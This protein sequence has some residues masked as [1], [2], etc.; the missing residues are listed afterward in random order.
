MRTT[1]FGSKIIESAEEV[2]GY[3]YRSF[4]RNY[5]G[6][7]LEVVVKE[8]DSVSGTSFFAGKGRKQPDYCA[9]TSSIILDKAFRSFDGSVNAIRSA[10][11]NTLGSLARSTGVR[12]DRS[13][14][15]GS[16]FI[17]ERN[18]KGQGHIGFVWKVKAG[19]IDTIEGNTESC[20]SY[21]I[22]E[23]C[24]VRLNCGEYGIL[25]RQRRSPYRTSAGKN[26]SFIHIEEMFGTDLEEFEPS[27][28]YLAD[29]TFCELITTDYDYEGS[30]GDASDPVETPKHMA[31]L[32][33]HKNKIIAGSCGVA[34]LLLGV[35][36]R[37]K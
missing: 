25:T 36:S 13:P 17:Y 27:E 24:P 37:N 1:L 26:F 11:A 6:E 23:G 15:V 18:A 20:S 10:S 30:D 19:H 9:I 34:I 33:T 5:F 12:V 22:K 35:L 14:S 31:F 4:N 21:I 7:R 2:L 3:G 16:L 29:G 32:H 28:N 8:F